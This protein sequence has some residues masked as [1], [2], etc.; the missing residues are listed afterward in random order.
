MKQ[1]ETI[2]LIYALARKSLEDP[3]KQK[4]AIQKIA[5]LIEKNFMENKSS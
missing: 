1:K 2:S 5:E 3:E 4:T